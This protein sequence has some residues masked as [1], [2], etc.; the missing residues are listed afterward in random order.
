MY[1]WT[2]LYCPS[3][4]ISHSLRTIQDP[5]LTIGPYS[6]SY[7]YS[8]YYFKLSSLSSARRQIEGKPVPGSS[9][10]RYLYPNT[11]LSTMI[12]SWDF[13]T[14]N[15]RIQWPNLSQSMPT[16]ST[17]TTPSQGS[18]CPGHLRSCEIENINPQAVTARFPTLM[19][20]CLSSPVPIPRS[21]S[22]TTR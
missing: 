19:A 3:T 4:P 10:T 22:T 16:W 6:Y 12:F 15:K 14:T 7:S 11:F 17:A 9:F 18:K 1:N 2:T 20:N 5:I 21:H 8:Y 13:A